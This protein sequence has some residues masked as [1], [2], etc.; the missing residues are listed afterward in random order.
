LAAI[1]ATA[2]FLKPNALEKTLPRQIGNLF[3]SLAVAAVIAASGLDIPAAGAQPAPAKHAP[4][5]RIAT[6]SG[7]FVLPE[8]KGPMYDITSF[9]AAPDGLA[10]HNQKA[11]NAAIDAAAE[12]G[13]GTVVIPAGTFKTYSI[14]LKSNV[15]LHFA[16]T[17]STLR[18]AIPGIGKD[19]DGGFYDAPEVNL[20]IGV[21]DSGHS[22]WANSLIY[23]IG[24]K[25][26]TIS[27]PGLIDG[28]YIDSTG[29]TVNVLSSGDPREGT[30]RTTL[31]VPGGANKA[32]A[33][34]NASNIVF[35]D[36]H[37]RNGG[38][39]AI[40][41][42]AVSRWT[43][44]GIIVDTN[45]DAIDI[46]TCQNVTVRNSVFNSLTDDA[47]VMKGS[48]GAGRY[49]TSRNILIERDTVSGYDAG[50]VL[51]KVYSTHKLVASDRDGPAAR[52]KFGTEGTSGLDTVTIR[53]VVFDRS[54]G[55]ALESVDGAE[56]KDIVFADIRMKNV[57]SSPIFI[58]L[59]DRGR[60]PVTGIGADLHLSPVGNV[61]L[62]NTGWILPDL[63]SEYGSYPPVRYIPSYDKST[64]VS[65]GGAAQSFT[66]VNQLA[67]ARLNPGSIRPDDP[68]FANAVGA[69]FARIHN[70]V[71]RNV[72]VEDADPRYP[73][74]LSGLVDH[75]I[76]DVS[77]SNVV[78]EYRGGLKME[79]AVEQRQLN[80][81]YA[82]TPYRGAPAT[83]SL[84]W[85]VNTF[86]SRN[87]ALLP[88]I[89]WDAASNDGKGSWKSDPYN[90]PE[91]TR[92]YP[93]PSM[94][95]ILPAYGIYAR[96]VK[97][98]KLSGIRLKY[99]VTDERPAVVLDDV[100]ESRF[101]G[102]AVMTAPGVPA[103]VE[104]T[105]TR[106]REPDQEY[107]KETPYKTTTV[108]HVAISPSLHTEKVTVDRP[109]PGTPPDALYAYPTAP[110]AEHPYAYSIADDKYPLPLTV[111]RP[112]FEPIGSKSI[113]AGNLLQFAVV[114]NTPVAGAKLS[115]SAVNLPSGASFDAET[116]TFSWTPGPR[117]AGTYT[118]TF[119]VDDGVLP[120]R[121]TVTIAV[122]PPAKP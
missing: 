88:R 17:D 120:E 82:Y 22:H 16:T 51:D 97:G 73:I 56:L 43:I 55:F 42:T 86:F 40:L 83:Q 30:L 95:G 100:G 2:A 50:S 117:Q 70:I 44:D 93:E 87:E 33:L 85:L 104:V 80:T 91:M 36:F 106:K 29:A 116:R 10:L 60:A 74:L 15:G 8:A 31:G 9:G 64:A 113:A 79:H 25:N 103:I 111:Y 121:T 98:L 77:I 118:V 47:V 69:G 89:S 107:V 37:I 72:V 90:V 67:P 112:S 7:V 39:F 21:Q 28:S 94:L 115:Y 62:E 19:H 101:S 11:I 5:I 54:R 76:Q 20:F 26:V 4:N 38:H 12:A 122:L 75:P 46:D 53:H 27:G 114:A 105:N 34:K 119:T 84:P 59:G 71:I 63:P 102:L 108:T 57:S 68:R 23:G 35:R 58:V 61:R 110:S 109:S 78:V 6:G 32:I 13:G 65:I 66:I 92:E 96:H 41:G 52:V 14:R 48:F 45:R 18:A 1:L 24:V 99:K 81:T 3:A 49:L